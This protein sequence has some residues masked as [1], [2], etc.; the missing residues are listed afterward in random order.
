MV[1]LRSSFRLA[2]AALFWL[3]LTL[4]ALAI[5]PYFEVDR[6]N[7]GLGAAPGDL[8]RST[9]QSTIEALLDAA[10]A[11]EFETAAHLMDLSDFEPSEQAARG[12]DLARKLNTII[13]RKVIIDWQF[14]LERP[15][16]LDALATSDSAVA[17]EVRRSLLMWILDLEDRSVAIRLNRI[18]PADGDAVWI[19]S[20]QSVANVDALFELYGP[21]RFEEW[22]PDWMRADTFWNLMIWEVIGLPI[23]LLLALLA[24]MATRRLMKRLAARTDSRL[25]GD[26]VHAVRMPLI[27]FVVTFVI[28]SLTTSLFVFSGQISTILGPLI[29]LGFVI[30]ALMLVVNVVDAVLDRMVNLHDNSLKE[31]EN[32]EFRA[33]VTR[34]AAGRRALIILIVLIG[35]GIVLTQADVFNTLGF[36]LLASAGALTLILAFA[37]RTV[38]GNIMA[39]MQIALNQA[40]RIGD[41]IVYKGEI[42]DVERIHFTYVQLRVWTGVRLIVPVNEFVSEPFE[43]W[44]LKHSELIRLIVLKM[45]HDADV[46]LFRKVFYDFAEELEEGELGEKDDL[47]VR[48][49]GQDVFG[50]DVTFCLPCRNP[51]TAWAMACEMREKLIRHG[52]SLEEKGEPIFPEAN[53][54]EAA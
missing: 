10:A 16:S 4:P 22:L 9:P 11:N 45:R 17:G 38:L 42:C 26:I 54:A 20:S 49:T 34:I 31:L 8:D 35:G 13:D 7:E 23:V 32:S 19:F 1:F 15:D 6:L 43:N 24:G 2:L 46:D 51:N 25:G 47:Q 36:S 53:P 39:S 44:T 52:R 12:E 21:T 29:A 3:C 27:F 40:A 37:A 18:K 14:L 48:V 50:Q 5:E 33:L 30:A 41:R 28:S